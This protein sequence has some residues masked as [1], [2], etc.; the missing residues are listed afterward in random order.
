MALTIRRAHPDEL[1]AV[2]R[3]TVDAYVPVASSRPTRRTWRFSGM[4]HTA[5]PRPRSGSRSTS[6]ASSAP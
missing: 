6:A 3:L 2:G 1:D 5:T 4:P